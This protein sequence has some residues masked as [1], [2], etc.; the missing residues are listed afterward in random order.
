MSIGIYS[1]GETGI[2]DPIIAN[3]GT[4]IDL[5]SVSIAVG[6]QAP[7]ILVGA[8]TDVP[9]GSMILVGVTP[10]LQTGVT[11]D[12]PSSSILVVGDNPAD[13]THSVNLL[14]NAASILQVS[15]NLPEILC[16]SV[17]DTPNPLGITLSYNQIII[18]AG[19]LS[20]IPSGSVGVLGRIPETIIRRR[21]LRA[22]VI[23]S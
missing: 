17:V 5:L 2:S 6:N 10:V 19:S 11:L 9:I 1:I 12:I 21:K 15:S 16:G 8:M 7:S 18:Q 20:N 23:M 4:S 3:T 22:S 14:V 13:V